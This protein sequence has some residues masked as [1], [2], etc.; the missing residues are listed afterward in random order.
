MKRLPSF[1]HNLAAIERTAARLRDEPLITHTA[2]SRERL[3]AGESL[4]DLLPEAYG[5][6]SEA[7]R[8]VRGRRCSPDELRAGIAMHHGAVAEVGERDAWGAAVTLAAC[9]GALEGRGVHVM[10]DDG[11]PLTIEVCGLLGLTVELLTGSLDDE[12]LSEAYA[13]D[14]T[15]GPAEQ[16]GYDHL[17][18]NRRWGPGERVGRGTYRAVLADADHLLLDRIFELLT[19]VRDGEGET[20]AS[21]SMRAYL[22]GYQHLTGVS[23]TARL[24]AD[25]I[26]FHYGLHVE[27]IAPDRPESERRDL[28]ELVYADTDA[29]LTALADTAERHHLT[30]RPVI[31]YT[32]TPETAERFVQLMTARG[33]QVN[34]PQ[35]RRPLARAGRPGAVTVLTDTRAAGEVVLG[36]D[37]EWLAEDAVLASGLDPLAASAQRWES[38][39]EA[40]RARLLP[41][42]AV[43]RQ[44]VIDAGG[45]VVLGAE[46]L[47]SERLRARVRALAGPHGETGFHVALDEGWLGRRVPAM[48]RGV[49]QD[50]IGGL[51]G[52]VLDR[53]RRQLAGR[54]TAFL[55]RVA[56]YDDV[57]IELCE[58]MHAERAAL[59]EG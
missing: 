35:P 4:D 22:R 30:G 16:F 42:C 40:A 43:A 21:M 38:A 15:V 20:L 36:G 24:D 1:D 56:A 45:P 34:V 33:L 25:E 32:T 37:V 5:A 11:A 52:W 47:L 10:T 28:H 9:L 50:P 3:A 14:V 29:K 55:R 54:H 39:L 19:L 23:A 59:V 18:D 44:R 8:R 27:P 7:V 53:S 6:I 46:L 26:A 17:Y 31:V 13:A 57:D 12:E 48:M 2:W 49:G 58:R 51:M 41:D